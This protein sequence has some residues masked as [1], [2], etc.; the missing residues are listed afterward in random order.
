MAI[1]IT[2][3][4]MTLDVGGRV[5]ANARFN[6]RAEVDGNGAWIVSAHP[7]RLSPATRRLPMGEMT[8]PALGGF[9]RQPTSRGN[10]SPS[11]SRVADGM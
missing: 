10:A 6:E 3:D 11:S 8:R 1:H 4:T 2:G 7:A 9:E 5:V